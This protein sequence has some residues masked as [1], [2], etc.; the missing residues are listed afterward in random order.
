[1]P[2]A[3]S[4]TTSRIWIF[5]IALPFL[6]WLSL[7]LKIIDNDF[8]FLGLTPLGFLAAFFLFLIVVLFEFQRSRAAAI[9][10]ILLILINCNSLFC[11]IYSGY[12]LF[13][14]EMFSIFYYLVA[15]VILI[16]QA[17]L[18]GLTLYLLATGKFVLR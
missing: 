4:S 3:E 5:L 7:D 6:F 9:F 13:S 2:I 12:S 17:I 14:F 1:M 15:N 16:S 18:A 8:G 10:G 11:F